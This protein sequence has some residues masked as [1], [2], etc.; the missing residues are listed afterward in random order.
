MTGVQTCAL[1]IFNGTIGFLIWGITGQDTYYATQWFWSIPDGIEAPDGTIVYSGIKYLQYENRGVTDIVLNI[2]YP[3]LDPTHP[4]VT[5][6]ERLGTISEKTPH[7][8]P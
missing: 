2:D 4:T 7:E 5:I 1:P 6:E 3:T 8:D